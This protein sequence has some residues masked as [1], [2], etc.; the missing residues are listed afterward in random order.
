[1]GKKSRTL[2]LVKALA[3]TVGLDEGKSKSEEAKQKASKAAVVFQQKPTAGG[4]ASSSSISM[5]TRFATNEAS[6]SSYCHTSFPISGSSASRDSSEEDLFAPC[7]TKS[8]ALITFGWR[9]F[10]YS[11]VPNK[12]EFNSTEETPFICKSQKPDAKWPADGEME[13]EETDNLID[14]AENNSSSADRHQS[15]GWKEANPFFETSGENLTLGGSLQDHGRPERPGFKNQHD[16][17]FQHAPSQGNR[18]PYINSRWRDRNQ[19]RQQR[20]YSNANPP[21]FNPNDADEYHD[22]DDLLPP[23]GTRPSEAWPSLNDDL[24]G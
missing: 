22:D 18:R 11:S 19:E 9:S 15:T 23:P 24:L 2:T 13:K 4:A 17:G 6:Q 3:A 14:E 16:D 12:E 5:E 8:G 21:A 1:M 20:S 10:S 7:I